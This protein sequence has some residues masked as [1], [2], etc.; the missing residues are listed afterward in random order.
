MTHTTLCPPKKPQ[1]LHTGSV[2][3]LIGT[4]FCLLLIMRNPEIAVAGV[5]KGLSLC[6]SGV[7]PSLF[8]FMVI[9]EIVVSGE[10]IPHLP[11]R[12]LAPLRRALGLS[13]TGCAAV[14]LGLLCG[15][16]VGARCAVLSLSQ[17]KLRVR[18]A[19]R[20]LTCSLCPSSAFVIGTLGVTLLHD[21]RLGGIIYLSS[22]LSALLTGMLFCLFEGSQATPND[23]PTT[24][25]PKPLSASLF[26]NAV[27]NAAKSVL[28]ISA[29]VVFFSAL[30]HSLSAVLAGFCPSPA[31]TACL[32][33]LLELSG[34]IAAA[35]AL[36]SRT[37]ALL[38]SAFCVGWSGFSVHCQIK[39]ICDGSRISLRPYLF[40]KLLQG[41]LCTALTSLFLCLEKAAFL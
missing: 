18:E 13:D 27:A 38:L 32:F 34:G 21:R 3:L 40:S 17:G 33:S 6:F 2:F 4:L 1:K 7:I 31:L 16:P 20:I 41:V 28:L 24:H 23:F 10:L 25:A 15:S 19:E 11:S 9:S 39:A 29:Y 30:M 26:T 35:S 8:P 14:I 12:L 22:L 5:G 37:L 36:E